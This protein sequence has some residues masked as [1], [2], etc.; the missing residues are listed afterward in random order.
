MH[1][2]YSKRQCGR[3]TR[4]GA[5]CKATF[6]FGFAC[7]RH[8][9]P[10]EDAY[11]RAYEEG[12][13]A[14]RAEGIEF[15]R[16]MAEAGAEN[17][18]RRVADLEEKLDRVTQRHSVD[19]HQ[20]VEVDGYAYLWTGTPPLG[21]GE[22]VLLPENYVSNLKHGPGPF[23]GVVTALGTT[24][25]GPLSRVLRRAPRQPEAGDR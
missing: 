8:T 22:R 17:L 1:T 24:Y 14:G 4:S 16:Q 21:L 15:G 5:P 7:G 11:V 6:T 23:I 13:R 12:H 3:P 9:T 2:G 20:A 18:R 25:D 10:E 19:G